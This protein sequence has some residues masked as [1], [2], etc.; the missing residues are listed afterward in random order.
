[1]FRRFISTVRKLTKQCASCD[2]PLPTPLPACH[3]CGTITP[4]HPT[5]RFHDIFALPDRP[6]P[7]I[8]DPL[9]LKRR[10]REAQAVCHPDTWASKGQAY[11]AL[12]DPLRRAEYILKQHGMP[13]AEGDQ[14]DDVEFISEIMQRREDIDEAE[15]ADGLARIVEAN[16]VKIKQTIEHLEDAVGREKWA[17]AK[18]AAVRLKYLEGIGAAGKEKREEM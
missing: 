7:F 3:K 16:A 1:M 4:I 10:F 8:V 2:S 13:I 15:D 9:L 5:V 11:H 6:N 18:D 12:S 17:I 14:L